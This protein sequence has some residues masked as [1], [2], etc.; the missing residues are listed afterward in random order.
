MKK[1]VLFVA[2]TALMLTG[3]PRTA[4]AADP[5]VIGLQGP[6]TG[7]WA[8]EGEMARRS[9]EIAAEL[10]NK[11]GGILGGRKVEVR[12]V[13]D[14]GEPKTGAL[15]AQK[16]VGQKDVAA[17]VATY[18]SSISE[19][20]ST[21]YEKFKKVNIGY[22]VTA[23]RL[24]QRGFKYFFRT[25]GRDD[26]QGAFFAKEV[27][28]RFNARRIAI[29]HDNTAFGK[30]LAEDTRKA[31]QDLA[32]A[33][34]VEVVFYDAV[35]PGEKDFRVILT[36]LREARPDVWYYTGYYAEAALLVSQARSIGVTCPFVGGNAA[37]NDE[38]VK[39]A[40]IEIAKGCYMTNEPLPSDLP[41]PEAR[42][43]LDAYRAKFGEIP[44]SPWPIYAADALNIIAHSIDKTGSTRAEV[45]ADYLRDKVN[46][47]PGITG[48]I[49]FTPQGDREGVPF[50][51]Y[52]VDASGRITVAK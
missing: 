42:E 33:A 26:S 45:L 10:I 51:L 3:L 2:V 9:C 35:T 13:D 15:A 31:L 18:G 47:V 16:L 34:R 5:V 48:P 8:Y 38:F 4:Q 12:V 22:G 32:G 52:V 7:P 37:I 30:G 6:I 29:M 27:P 43:F 20:A 25:C 44:S 50:Y 28:S 1:A 17:A 40:G 21:I 24:T 39:I 36:K 46:G 11:K 14:A 23:V 19:T 41:Y 49:G